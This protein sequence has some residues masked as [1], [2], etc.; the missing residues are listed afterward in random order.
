MPH[1]N[2]LVADLSILRLAPYSAHAQTTIIAPLKTDH[3]MQTEHTANTLRR[4]P[5]L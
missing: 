3:R 1:A 2:F 5:R 4:E